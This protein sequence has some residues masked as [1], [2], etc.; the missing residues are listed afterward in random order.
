MRELKDVVLVGKHVGLRVDLNVPI[1][2]GA[3]MND[4][5]LSATLPTILE[6]L[7]STKNLTIISHLGR[8]KE[9]EYSE[10]LSLKPIV[11][12]FE[13]RLNL[14][15]PLVKSLDELPNGISFLENIRMFPGESRNDDLLSE[16]LS[17]KFDIYIMDAFA[18][19]HREASS[20]YGAILKSKDS[21]PGLLFSREINA[22]SNILDDSK[23]LLSIVGGSKV[24]TKLEVITNLLSKSDKVLVGGGI[25]NTFLK[26][27]GFDIGTS[28]VEDDMISSA[29]KMLGTGKIILPERVCISKSTQSDDIEFVP[30]ESVPEDK[31]ILDIELNIKELS[32]QDYDAILWNG[33]LGIFEIKNF[34]KG[35][36]DLVKYLTQSG[37]RVVAGGGETIFAISK[38]SD[39]KHFH[40]ISTAGGAFLEFISGKKL[41][42]VEALELK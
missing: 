12:W 9:G 5:R 26:A 38:Y 42:S 31:M 3:V 37:S 39:K 27:K 33:P 25:A 19:A 24:S 6:I 1:E 14:E 29:K 11:H 34:E 32:K 10:E 18:T 30:I 13:K 4:E 15:I 35:T 7:K 41:P 8:P 21:V 16:L 2:D 40:Y 28:L 20:T 22:L 17:K 23:K 36:R